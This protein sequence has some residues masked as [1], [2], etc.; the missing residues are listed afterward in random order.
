MK[1]SLTMAIVAPAGLPGEMIEISDR[2]DIM[3]H[4]FEANFPC[5]T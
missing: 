4:G 5:I 1:G 2:I 3:P